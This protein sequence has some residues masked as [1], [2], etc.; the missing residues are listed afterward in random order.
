MMIVF[1]A[2]MDIDVDLQGQFEV[3]VRG[4]WAAAVFR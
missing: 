1:G 3:T 4:R 2:L